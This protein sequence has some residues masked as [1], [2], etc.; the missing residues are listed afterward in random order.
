MLTIF[1]RVPLLRFIPFRALKPPET[2]GN[3]NL[4][5]HADCLRIHL[6]GLA[7]IRVAS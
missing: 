1:N 4:I 2:G 3:L 7:R 5:R 6:A